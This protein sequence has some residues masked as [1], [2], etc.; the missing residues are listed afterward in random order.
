V[1][2]DPATNRVGR[3]VRVGRG[4][5]GVAFGGGSVWVA[6]AIA[7]TVTRVDPQTTSVVATIRIPA[8]P[9]AL[10]VGE[11]SLWVVGD[12]R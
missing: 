2:I 4:A 11:G 12:A 1:R 10:T 5:G 7:H 8:R 3:S 9:R 6:D